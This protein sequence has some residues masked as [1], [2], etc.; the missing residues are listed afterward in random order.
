LIVKSLFSK[1]KW[2]IKISRSF[3]LFLILFGFVTLFLSIKIFYKDYSKAR[4]VV[5]K[6]LEYQSQRVKA[7]FEDAIKYSQS[8]MGYI[9]DQIVSHGKLDEL[10]IKKLL[11]SYK[12]PDHKV[13]EFSTFSWVNKNHKLVISSNSGFHSGEN[14]DLSKRD[15]IPKTIS[16][17][18]KIHLGNMV[19]GIYS[20]KWSI[21]AGYGV[22]DK[23]N[24]YLGAVVIGFVID[25]LK[26]RLSETISSK[27]IYFAILQLNGDIVTS[28]SSLDNKDIISLLENN[29]NLILSKDT[30]IIFK[31][32]FSSKKPYGS[33]Y[34]NKIKDYPYVILT[35]YDKDAES[36][37]LF[38][39][40]QNYF[41]VF[42]LIFIIVFIAIFIVY[43]NLVKPIVQLSKAI[44]ELSKGNENINLPKSRCVEIDGLSKAVLMVKYSISKELQ[45]VKD[46]RREN[47][48][49]DAFL[50]SVS[51]DLRNP[52][53]AIKNIVESLESSKKYQELGGK[54]KEDFISK[55]KKQAEESLE[56]INELLDF[57][58]AKTGNVALGFV[59]N[60]FIDEILFQV[61]EQNKSKAEVRNIEIQQD[62]DCRL[63]L[64][65]SK[66]RISQIFANL[67]TNSIKYSP[68]NTIVK[69]SLKKLGKEN[70]V[71]TISDKG[72]GMSEEEIAMAL[73]GKGKEIEIDSIDKSDSHG[74]GLPNVVHLVKLHNAKMEI[75][76]QKGQGTSV[77]ITFPI[78]NSLVFERNK[79]SILLVDDDLVSIKITERVIKNNMGDVDVEVFNVS[80]GMRAVQKI[81]DGQ[82][83]NFILMDIEM[84][85]MDGITALKEI[86]KIDNNTPIISHSS[87]IDRQDEAIKAG[88]NGFIEK[89]PNKESLIRN[90]YKWCLIKRI[91]RI[92]GNVVRNNKNKKILLVEDEI[93]S[94]MTMKKIL[95]NQGFVVDI[96][97]NGQDF[98]NKILKKDHGYD[99]VITDINMP[100]IDGS[101]VA[102]IAKEFCKKN[103]HKL[104]PIIA[105]S[106]DCDIRKIHKFLNDGIFD[107]F[108]K[109][110]DI[111]YVL[112]MID[113]YLYCRQYS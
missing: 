3:I 78:E 98:L 26:N 84:P 55:I 112:K 13:L 51:H 8:N 89:S 90:I 4:K 6:D 25:G 61:I 102:K 5:F 62:V 34:F 54:D 23:N 104:I 9:A 37:L 86:R 1:Q 85:E 106:G 47:L 35:F 22:V 100:D 56:F 44:T 42:S 88:A 81:K 28:N 94:G 75:K 29:K 68:D 16:E 93:I 45:K 32:H 82:K 53:G 14:L 18:K 57:K 36:N 87:T 11:E 63:E 41:L 91:P 52:I 49:K 80:D 19:T 103:N 74:V 72:Y 46:A 33:V 31:H 96:V 97:K 105:Y 99:L 39:L 30:D 111:S 92:L 79:K 20:K 83:F 27:N 7:N 17:P 40:A 15:Y 65:C 10:F 101:E 59:A 71:F 43:T 21:P 69:I 70:I 2:Q 110:D 38:S 48:N 95:M 66:K 76:S 73:S 58:Q 50:S 113:F 24:N 12:L 107:Y 77:S 64:N 109:G 67:I 108:N 60:E